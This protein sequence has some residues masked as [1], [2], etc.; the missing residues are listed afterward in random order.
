MRIDNN[1]AANGN[2]LPLLPAGNDILGTP[3]NTT[4]PDIGAYESTSLNN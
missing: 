1:S 3:R 4:E 2:A